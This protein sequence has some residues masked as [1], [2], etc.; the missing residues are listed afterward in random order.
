MPFLGT[1]RVANQ[2]ISN[3][4][5]SINYLSYFLQ[6]LVSKVGLGLVDVV[7]DFLLVIDGDNH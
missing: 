1:K 4:F 6:I 3:S 7:F 5:F 2:S